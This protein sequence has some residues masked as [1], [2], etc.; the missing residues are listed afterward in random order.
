MQ[1]TPLQQR[2]PPFIGTGFIT[3]TVLWAA[4]NPCLLENGALCCPEPCWYSSPWKTLTIDDLWMST[5]RR[6]VWICVAVN[7][8]GQLSLTAFISAPR[9]RRWHAF[10][11]NAYISFRDLFSFLLF[12]HVIWTPA[13]WRPTLFNLPRLFLSELN[14]PLLVFPD[15]ND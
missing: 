14:V 3:F 8:L 11:R 10:T 1:V 4:Y 5:R 9:R 6:V 13:S 2:V 12:T 7:F 15:L